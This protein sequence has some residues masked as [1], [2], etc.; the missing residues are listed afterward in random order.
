MA[1]LGPPRN[2]SFDQT[3]ITKCFQFPDMY[4]EW[5][6]RPIFNLKLRHITWM[7]IISSFW[8]FSFQGEKANYKW[9]KQ[10][11]NAGE[12]SQLKAQHLVQ[13]TF[14]VLSVSATGDKIPKDPCLEFVI[15]L[16]C[17]C[18]RLGM[19]DL[20]SFAPPCLVAGLKRFCSHWYYTANYWRYWLEVK[21]RQETG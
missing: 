12:P 13:V 4:K 9:N 2:W 21:I 16:C 7:C 14:N 17:S 15:C 20:G 6:I 18:S 19:S 8:H 5:S 11:E 1:H 3:N 10:T